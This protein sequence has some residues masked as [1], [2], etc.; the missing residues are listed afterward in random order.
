MRKNIYL[1]FVLVPVVFL[2]NGCTLN[3]GLKIS[4][5]LIEVYGRCT[6]NYELTIQPGTKVVFK[7]KQTFF[8]GGGDPGEIEFKDGGKL[9]AK[10]TAQNPIVF[11]NMQISIGHIYLR[12]NASNESIME[13]I[14]INGIT[15]NIANSSLIQK[16][17]F[18]NEAW[19]LISNNSPLVKYNTITRT[20]MTSGTGIGIDGVGGTNPSPKIHY[21]NIS[22]GGGYGISIVFTNY[23]DIR[24]NNITNTSKGAVSYTGSIPNPMTITIYDNYISDC[25]GQSGV[26]TT[27][28]QSYNVIYVNP[29]TSPV[30][31][32]GCGW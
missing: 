28:S 29:R 23:P 17:K 30:P 4:N 3:E 25:K 32:A 24:Y 22:G 10:G 6:V 2:I 18:H 19:I 14:D 16:C 27:G 13:Y 5:G 12:E 26:D 15:I 7:E 11:E 1:F 8:I 20:E 9:I 21:N 31:E